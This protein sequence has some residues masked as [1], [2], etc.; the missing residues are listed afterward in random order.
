M[1]FVA[2]AMLIISILFFRYLIGTWAPKRIIFLIFVSFQLAQVCLIYLTYSWTYSKEVVIQEKLLPFYGDVWVL[3]DTRQS[4][5]Y[6][7]KDNGSTVVAL[8]VPSNVP[9]QIIK[10]E[11]A[12]LELTVFNVYKG[13]KNLEAVY[14]KIIFYLPNGNK[15]VQIAEYDEDVQEGKVLK[16]EE[17]WAE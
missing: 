8:A 10:Q 1:I 3:L 15:G 12:Q 6:Y 7:L 4:K 13:P 2:V 5:W 14:K 9:T 17:G 16:K 11:K